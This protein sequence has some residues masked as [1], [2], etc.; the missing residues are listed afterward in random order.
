M[1]SFEKYFNENFRLQESFRKST[2][3]KHLYDV[4]MFSI[5]AANDLIWSDKFN[6]ELDVPRELDTKHVRNIFA[7]ARKRINKMGFPSMHSNVVFK[8]LSKEKNRNTGE[9][10]GGYAHRAGKYMSVDYNHFLN[11]SGDWPIRVIVHEWAHL[12]MYN[13]SKG[14]KDAVK[15]YYKSLIDTQKPNISQKQETELPETFNKL[16][17]KQLTDV[18]VPMI[19][20]LFTKSVMEDWAV[21]RY[22]QAYNKLSINDAEFLPH[23]SEI[24]G[25]S[26]RKFGNVDIGDDV[27]ADKFNRGWLLGNKNKQRS[28]RTDIQIPFNDLLNYLDISVQEAETQFNQ[29]RI[30]RGMSKIELKQGVSNAI[31]REVERAL[32]KTMKNLN[33]E[34]RFK[35]KNSKEFVDTAVDILLPNVLKYLRNIVRVPDLRGNVYDKVWSTPANGRVSYIKEISKYILEITNTETTLNLK[36]AKNF[37][38]EEYNSVRKQMKNLVGWANSYGMSNDD[39]L[40]ATG[41]EYFL[42]LPENHRKSI[43]KLMET[44]GART[45]PNRRLRKH[46]LENLK[47]ITLDDFDSSKWK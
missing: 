16:V 15:E 40:W 46:K 2:K 1:I 45:T 29:V 25:K 24:Y 17:F 11:D 23:L 37:S 42:K 47:K 4:P 28:T 22:V 3:I 5:F 6:H 32:E 26:K 19:E 33:Y 39:E 31:K 8:D 21:E 38:G 34:Y 44:K 9:G 41:I 18:W 36:N 7:E 12:W 20:G 10:V 27:Y 30:P 35:V 13:N 43:L 14:F